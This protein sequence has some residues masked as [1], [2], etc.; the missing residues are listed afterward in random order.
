MQHSPRMLNSLRCL[1][2][3]TVL[4]QGEQVPVLWPYLLAQGIHI[5]FAHQNI[6]IGQASA[7]QG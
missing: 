7:R 1:S 4:T 3:P 2:Q 5:H 6:F